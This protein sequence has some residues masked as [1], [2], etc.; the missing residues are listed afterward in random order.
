MH[1]MWCI[2]YCT[3]I[4]FFFL[5]LL[6]TESADFDSRKLYHTVLFEYDTMWSSNWFCR[7]NFECVF[8]SYWEEV[9][10]VKTF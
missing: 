8:S 10:H 1:P 6:Y 4:L 9:L 7:I 2:I 3:N 5:A